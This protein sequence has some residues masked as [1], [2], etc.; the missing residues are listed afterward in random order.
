MF[1]SNSI[2]PKISKHFWLVPFD[3]L[4]ASDFEGYSMEHMLRTFFT[5]HVVLRRFYADIK[6]YQVKVAR[7]WCS[8][9][10]SYQTWASCFWCIV[11]NAFAVDPIVMYTTNNDGQSM[12]VYGCG[13]HTIKVNRKGCWRGC[14]AIVLFISNQFS[15]KRWARFWTCPHIYII[16]CC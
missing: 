11:G 7:V 2:N 9:T 13:T 4:S 16:K 12:S 3:I 6:A 8:V 14:T 1:W 15:I 10:Q 5:V